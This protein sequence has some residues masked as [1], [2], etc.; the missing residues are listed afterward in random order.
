[1]Q[2]T[3]RDYQNKYVQEIVKAFSEGHKRIVLCA[4]TGSGKTVMFSEM[5]RRAAFKETST[6]VLLIIF[7]S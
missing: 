5:V 2:I 1:M 7:M 6:W 3:L 4:P